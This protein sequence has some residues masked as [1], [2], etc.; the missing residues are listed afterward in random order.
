MSF[1]ARLF[2]AILVAVLVPLTAL[3][4]GVRREMQRRL[5]AEYEGRVAALA[6][7][8][9]TALEQESA[10]V[11]RR[12]NA[13]ASDLTDDNRFRLGLRG[14]PASRKYLLDYASQ[15]MRLSGLSYLQLQDSTGKIL[16]SGHFRNEFDRMQPELPRFLRSNPASLA[17]V[18]T[19]TAQVPILALVRMDSLR[20]SGVP[21]SLIGGIEAES[22]L[23]GG[24]LPSDLGV[25]LTY[26]GGSAA[27]RDARVVRR[28][29]LPFLDLVSVTGPVPDTAAFVMTHSTGTLEQLL[30]GVGRWVLIA[31]A[32]TLGVAIAAAA[33]LSSRISRPL[34]E[35]AGKTAAIDLDRLDQNF[36]S[37]RPDEIGALSR[38][39]GAM[40][41]RLRS[42]STRI[43]EA[44]RRAA[45]GDLARQVNHDIKNGLAPI[46]NVLRHLAQVA[47]QEPAT[48]PQVFEARR[49]TLESSV[50]YLDTLA[51]NY[52]RLSPGLERR[53]CDINA[54][55]EQ[56]VRNASGD[57]AGLRT[58]LD[59]RLPSAVGDSLMIRRVLENLVG[60]ALDSIAG[61]AGASVTVSTEQLAN[62]IGPSSVRIVVA[63]TGPG[64]TQNELDRAFDDFYTTKAGGSGLGLSIVRRLIL[65]LNGSLRV[66]TAPGAGTR[67]VVELPG[68]PTGDAAA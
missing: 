56:V 25:D 47:S 22:R 2:V 5:T 63:D 20:L 33:W 11:A 41:D 36:D 13:L 12:L 32:L 14:E 38:L 31:L 53:P 28:L 44:E 67:V 57:G 30:Q 51:R 65:D 9:E 1:R 4:L 16:S 29:P 42:S 27:A 55:V 8:M 58:Q 54:I 52:D 60:N 64:M 17:L 6:S 46:R 24:A 18:R 23:L 43:R 15:A 34:R 49:A 3:A 21:I 35:L 48:L 66:E 40:T 61:R 50:E 62:G 39:L 10:T 68:A 37:D 45:V 26:P 19:R 59:R 7:V